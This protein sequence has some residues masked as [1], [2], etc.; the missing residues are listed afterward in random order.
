VTVAALLARPSTSK[1]KILNFVSDVVSQQEIADMLASTSGRPVK[2]DY[3][4]IDEAHGY[5][6][7]PETIPD[8]AKETRF[9]PEFWYIVRL[10]Q[11]RFLG[12]LSYNRSLDWLTNRVWS[13]CTA[14]RARASSVATLL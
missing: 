9:A 6:D 11:V 14:D 12:M 4:S 5:I 2:P 1:D 13:P 8:R 10:Q 7:R 3:V